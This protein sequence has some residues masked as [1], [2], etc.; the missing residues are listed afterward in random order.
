MSLRK[1][2]TRTVAFLEANR[3]NAQK[4]TGPRTAQG[5]AWTRFNSLRDGFRS[6]ECLEFMKAL[7]DAPP[8]RV[9]PTALAL[10]EAGHNRHP[11]FREVAEMSLKVE[12]EICDELRL[13]RARSEKQKRM[14][15][16]DEQSRNVIENKK[17]IR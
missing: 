10:L 5:K 17:P 6:R 8:G 12:I 15:F 13:R 16:F 9:G 1:S 2:P 11:M 4:S 14:L 3:R 7:Y